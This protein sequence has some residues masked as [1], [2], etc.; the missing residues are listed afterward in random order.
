MTNLTDLA[1]TT[2]PGG[3]PEIGLNTKGAVREAVEQAIEM[4]TPARRAPRRLAPT[5][6]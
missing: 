6:S 4:S 2:P 1:A 5:G 3:R